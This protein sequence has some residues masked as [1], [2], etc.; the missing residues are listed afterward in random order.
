MQKIHLNVRY[1][2]LQPETKL[3]WSTPCHVDRSAAT[4]MCWIYLPPITK[5]A[6]HI[7]M[8]MLSGKFFPIGVTQFGKLFRSFGSL[9]V[10]LPL[11]LGQV[12]Q[13]DLMV[14]H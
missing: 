13:N 11:S 10:L 12:W 5:G 4:T 9:K 14:V 3:K 6:I 1:T 2:I 8:T 7:G